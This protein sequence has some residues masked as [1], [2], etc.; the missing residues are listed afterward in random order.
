MF[1]IKS[2][3]RNCC[4]SLIMESEKHM[5]FTDQTYRTGKILEDKG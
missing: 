2:V 5:Y 1:R 3:F 4:K